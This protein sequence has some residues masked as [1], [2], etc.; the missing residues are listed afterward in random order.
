MHVSLIEQNLSGR[1]KT[2]F[3]FLL[4][5]SFEYADSDGELQASLESVVRDRHASFLVLRLPCPVRSGQRRV[6]CPTWIG[7]AAPSGK[8]TNRSERQSNYLLSLLSFCEDSPGRQRNFPDMESPWDIIIIDEELHVSL[9]GNLLHV[10]TLSN[11]KWLND[12]W[13]DRSFGQHLKNT[14]SS[15]IL[16][17]TQPKE[18]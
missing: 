12:H 9:Y 3:G 18:I 17:N 2:L 15:E 13:S 6:T 16:M 1:D 4:I 7:M 11:W 14:C 5:P 8:S 10:C